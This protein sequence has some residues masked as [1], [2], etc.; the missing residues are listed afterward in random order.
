MCNAMGPVRHRIN[1]SDADLDVDGAA[2]YIWGQYLIRGE[3][4]E[5]R[6]DNGVS[7]DFTPTWSGSHWSLSLGSSSFHG[8]ILKR[9]D[10]ATVKSNSNGGSDGRV[11]LAVKVTGPDAVTGL[12]HYEYAA[13][14]RDNSRGIKT[15]HIPLRPDAKISNPGFRDIDADATNDWKF[16]SEGGEAIW[17]T[18]VNPLLWNTIY[19]FWFDCD[20]PPAKGN[21]ALV[22]EDQPGKGL[23]TFDITTTSPMGPS[24][25]TDLGFGK[26]GSNG[27]AP[28]LAICGSL[29]AGAAAQ[30]IVR[31]ALPDALTLV[32]V[33]DQNGGFP[34]HGGTLVPYPPDF[35]FLTSTDHAGRIQQKVTGSG[36]SFD[37]FLQF[38]VFDPA[39]D[40]GVAMTNALELVH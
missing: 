5:R 23:D 4:D 26:T 14:N 17:T 38:V 29:D 35:L 11:F 32:F 39:A 27:L 36:G 1:V 31:Y 2:Y 20:M 22:D 34:Y 24:I 28:D 7:R 15:L 19:N 37:L 40:G 3:A 13:N 30:V 10:G 12:Y 21:R 6:D 25:G 16:T 18:D 8:T 9:W 33:G